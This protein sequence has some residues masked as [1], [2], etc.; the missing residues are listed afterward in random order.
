MRAFQ[1]TGSRIFSN[2]KLPKFHSISSI[3]LNL[4][5]QC[6]EL[7][8]FEVNE[9]EKNNRRQKCRFTNRLRNRRHEART[10]E[11][12]KCRVRT[13]NSDL[14]TAHAAVPYTRIMLIYWLRIGTY[15]KENF[16]KYK[17]ELK[18]NQ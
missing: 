11:C 4:P 5:F 1:R 2:E 10:C 15:R 12:E 16:I 14:F 13:Y 3:L 7:S 18:N 6:P 9:H 8:I 17:V